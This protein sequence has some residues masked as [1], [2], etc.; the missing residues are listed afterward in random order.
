MASHTATP[1]LKRVSPA[2]VF[3]K[4]L[5]KPTLWDELKGKI[6]MDVIASIIAM[7]QTASS[8]R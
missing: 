5:A 7:A 1:S 6:L 4:A 2:W 3:Q 8:E